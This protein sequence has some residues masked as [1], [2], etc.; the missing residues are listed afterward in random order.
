MKVKDYLKEE[1]VDEAAAMDMYS[2]LVNSIDTAIRI[3]DV[4]VESKEE[5]RDLRY[6]QSA[7]VKLQAAMEDVKKLP[8]EA[9]KNIAVKGYNNIK[10][11]IRKAFGL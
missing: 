6:L 1:K 10:S 11:G 9:L 2:S 3:I 7:K 8:G 4:A 5:A